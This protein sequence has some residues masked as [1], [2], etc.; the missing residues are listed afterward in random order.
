MRTQLLTISLLCAGSLLAQ[1]QNSSSGGSRVNRP[2]DPL[3]SSS[4]SKSS[5]SSSSSSSSSPGSSLGS[6]SSYGSS[7]RLGAT[8]RMGQHEIRASKLTSSSVKTSTGE[9][10]GKIEDVIINPASGRIDFAVISY[11]GSS[12]GSSSSTSGTSSSSSASSQSTP[13]STS[14]SI[15]T[16]SGSEKLVAI[17]WQLIRPSG[18]LGYNSSAST[19]SST[20][21]SSS[22]EEMSFVFTGDKS[23]LEGAPSFSQSNWPDLTQ[24]SWRQSVFSYFGVQ[25]G[26]ATG[27]SFSPGGSSSGSST[28]PGSSSSSSSD[29]SQSQTPGSPTSPRQP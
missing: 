27:G 17:P 22:S 26:S 29:S 4:G 24:P 7:S 6:S 25:P 11:S 14:G 12:S 13:G 2:D 3:S 10:L 28:S 15:S 5:D 23:K 19:S 16:T 9:D 1:S 20:S 18:A 8:G 21:T